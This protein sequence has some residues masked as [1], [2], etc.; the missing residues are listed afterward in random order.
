MINLKIILVTQKNIHQ[1]LYIIVFETDDS[2][3][4]TQIRIFDMDKATFFSLTAY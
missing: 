3:A 4:L 1:S 2:L